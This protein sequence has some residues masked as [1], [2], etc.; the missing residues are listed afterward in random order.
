MIPDAAIPTPSFGNFRLE[1]NSTRQ[2]DPLVPVSRAVKAVT[3][4]VG[5]QAW[6]MK[7]RVPLEEQ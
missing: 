3:A 6:S 1:M 7:I 4:N 2:A 5:S